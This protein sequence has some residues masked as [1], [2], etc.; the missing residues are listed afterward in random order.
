MTA[1]TRSDLFT[2]EGWDIADRQ[3]IFHF[4]CS[5]H[6]RFSETV[7]PLPEGSDPVRPLSGAE[8]L[9]P[10]LAAAIGVSYYKAGAAREISVLPP[11]TQAGQAMI[12]ALYRD[13]LAEF[14]VRSGLEF[15]PQTDFSFSETAPTVTAGR[16]PAGR[17]VSAFG[18]GKDSFVALAILEKAG[19]S[20]EPCSLVMS[21]KVAKA[22]AATSTR[23]VTFLRRRLDPHLGEV[24]RAGAFNGH[25]PI[26]AINSLVL[27]L[28][29]FLTGARDAVFANE[30]SADEATIITEDW[31]ANHQYS[32]SSAF[33]KL[34][35]EAVRSSLS[36]APLYYSV[37]RPF[38]E[39]RIA[40]AFTALKTPFSRFTSCNGNFRIAG[41]APPRWCGACAKCAFTSLLLAPSLTRDDWAE[42]FTADFLNSP[43]LLPFYRELCGLTAAKPWD[44]VGTIS[45]CRATLYRLSHN[46]LWRDTLAVRT[47]MPEVLAIESPASLEAAWADGLKLHDRTALPDDVARAAEELTLDDAP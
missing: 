18:G 46:P 31:Q 45:E 8:P 13:G 12:Q 15:P 40:R 36:D 26:T 3:V 24:T 33:E 25:V 23:P 17:A 32:K 19:L 9:L 2:I 27:V 14:F 21:D 41:E 4:T 6:G 43:D 5:R 7:W 34:L 30:R 16:P 44:C 28:Y 38:S 35:R 42:I 29:G 10:L 47:L 37:L 20:V 22:I 1:Q 39:I 11:V